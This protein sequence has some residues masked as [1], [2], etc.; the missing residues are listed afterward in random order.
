M[1]RYGTCT[2]C[3]AGSACYYRYLSN[4][5]AAAAQAALTLLLLPLLLRCCLLFCCCCNAAFL[6][7][8][9]GCLAAFSPLSTK[10]NK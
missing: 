1:Y 10:N 4:L 7:L 8:L 2:R 3:T 9:L 5:Y 6:W